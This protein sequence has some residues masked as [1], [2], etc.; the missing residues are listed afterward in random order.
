MNLFCLDLQCEVSAHKMSCIAGMKE[1]VVIMLFLCCSLLI[2]AAKRNSTELTDML[3]NIMKN[4]DKRVLPTK[5]GKQLAN[6][7]SA[8]LA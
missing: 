3:R 8:T 4:Y 5:D 1:R 6:V 7:L 2:N